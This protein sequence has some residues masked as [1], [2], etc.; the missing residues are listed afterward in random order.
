M[1]RLYLRKLILTIIPSAG[2]NRIID[3]L[4]M[5]INAEKTNSSLFNTATIQIYNLSPETKGIL[6]GSKT[7]VMLEAGYEDT[8]ERLF[9]GDVDKVVHKTEELDVVSTLEVQDGGNKFRNA[10]LDKGYPPNSTLKSV[11]DDMAKEMGT[12]KGLIL[13]VGD[14]KFG[15]GVSFSGLVR[16]H[17][18][19]LTKTNDLEWSIQDE[20]LQILPKLSA[21]TEGVIILSS[22]TG[23]IKSPSKTDKGVEFTSLLQPRLKPGRRVFVQSENMTGLF[24]VRKVTHK[25]DNHQGDFITECEATT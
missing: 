12:D 1:G 10:R 24:K 4:R 13:G 22:D 15:H 18:D 14:Q 25:G 23:L 17:L 2:P 7:K 19:Q 9:I 3:E 21:S 6:E 16:D 5:T 11:I 8:V 20:V